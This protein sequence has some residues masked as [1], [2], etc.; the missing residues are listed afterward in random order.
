MVATPETGLDPQQRVPAAHSHWKHV[1]YNKPQQETSESPST[2]SVWSLPEMEL[3]VRC[4]LR[5]MVKYQGSFFIWI[6]QRPLTVGCLN[7][8]RADGSRK[9]VVRER[10]RKGRGATEKEAGRS[11]RR[12]QEEWTESGGRASG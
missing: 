6:V 9:G 11:T 3:L 1:S 2:V 12:E 7:N 8:E 4:C 5:R 10:E